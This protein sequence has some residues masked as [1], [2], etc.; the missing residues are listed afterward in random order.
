MSPKWNILSIFL[1]HVLLIPLRECFKKCKKSI[2][3]MTYKLQKNLTHYYFETCVQVWVFSKGWDIFSSKILVFLLK[4]Q[5]T[6]LLNS[7]GCTL[8]LQFVL[9][10]MKCLSN[11]R[12]KY[13]ARS[14]ITSKKISHHSF[15][16]FYIWSGIHECKRFYGS[17]HTPINVS[18]E[19]NLSYSNVS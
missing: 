17:N 19:V 8:N 14:K 4:V 11:K 9:L 5:V 12:M 10:Q 2:W 7:T 16:S 18:L 6:I 15:F 3:M 1:L 13:N